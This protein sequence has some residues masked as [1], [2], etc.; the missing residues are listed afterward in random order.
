MRT[1]NEDEQLKKAKVLEQD[2]GNIKVSYHELD[3]SK[4]ESI[5][6]FRDYLKKEHSQGIDF[7]INNAGLSRL[8]CY[9]V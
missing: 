7:V 5:H 9:V 2:G 6:K 4:K 8:Y 3:I 1:L